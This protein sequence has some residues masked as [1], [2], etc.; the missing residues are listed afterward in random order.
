MLETVNHRHLIQPSKYARSP[1][2]N[3]TFYR[4]NGVTH[5]PIEL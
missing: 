5:K 3:D 4:Q 2:V 1:I